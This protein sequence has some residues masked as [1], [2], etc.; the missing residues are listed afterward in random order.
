MQCINGKL[1]IFGGSDGFRFFNDLFLIDLNNLVWQKVK[2]NGTSPPIR[3]KHSA[4]CYGDKMLI[5][6]GGDTSS[7]YGDV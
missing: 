3:Y 6:G 2:T 4:L 1:L 5:I 7:H